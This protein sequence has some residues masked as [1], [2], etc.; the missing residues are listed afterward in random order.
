MAAATNAAM[1]REP[2][3]DFASLVRAHQAMVFS[4]ALH[5]LH[6]RSAAE[7]LAQDVFLQFHRSL[8]DMQ[9][10]AH[11]ARWLRKVAVHR[12]IDHARRSRVRPQV[13][14]EDAQEPS[15]PAAVGD[16]MLSQRLRRLVASLPEKPRAVVLLR[17]QED[18]DPEEIAT[19]LGM[20]VRTVKSHLQRSLAMLREKA[21]RAFTPAAGRQ[22]LSTEMGEVENEP[23]G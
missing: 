22:N 11:A 13:G 1:G 18:L 23:L 3:P 20:P 12:S 5:Y 14:L 17:Y 6:D 4:I 15:V 10:A 8:A 2:L 19:A 7:E 21:S 9:S 16:P